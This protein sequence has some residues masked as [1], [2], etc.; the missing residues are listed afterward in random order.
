M[1]DIKTTDKVVL[2]TIKDLDNRSTIGIAKYGCDLMRTD[3]SLKDFLNHAYQENLD[4][5]LYLK[6]AILEIEMAEDHLR[7][8]LND[9]LRN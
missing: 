2:E 9:E 5:A 1:S 3:L 4:S 8:E 6:R 7:E